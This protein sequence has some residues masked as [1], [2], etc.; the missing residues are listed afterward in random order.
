[1]T[2]AVIDKF[3]MTDKVGTV[4]RKEAIRFTNHINCSF[5]AAT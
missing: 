2:R 3:K 5:L 4:N 1:M